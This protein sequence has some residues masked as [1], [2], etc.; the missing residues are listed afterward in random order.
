ME[1]KLQGLPETMLIPLWARAVETERKQSIIK[2]FKAQQIIKKIDYDFSRFKKSW[3]SQVGISVRT[4][5]LDEATR[6]FLQRNPEAVII[7]LGSGLDTRYERLKDENIAFWYDVDVPESLVLRRMFFSE[8]KKNS[9][10]A[11]SCL[12][13]SW[14]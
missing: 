13:E 5:L 9:C 6:S 2:D 14:I 7:N 4:M 8:G 10:I 11:L 12:D 3:L 1:H